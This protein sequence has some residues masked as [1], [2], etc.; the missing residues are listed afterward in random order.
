MNLAA[1]ALKSDFVSPPV[2]ETLA[3]RVFHGKHRTLTIV[4]AKRDAVIIAE[5]V[6]R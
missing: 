3:S 6:L 1:C 4:E 2:R 5:I